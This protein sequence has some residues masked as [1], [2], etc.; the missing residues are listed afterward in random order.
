MKLGS[1]KTIPWRLTLEHTPTESKA[2]G[3]LLYIFVKIPYKL[4]NDLNVYCPK[5]LE[6]VF[7]ELLLSNKPSQIIGTIYKHPSMNA[8]TFTNGHL[9][10]M[11]NAIHYE[12][13]ITLLT[14][15]FNV[16]LINYDKKRG[17]YNFFELLFNQNF[18][19]QITL[20]TRVNEKSATL[21]DNI[22]VNNPSFKYLCGNITTSISDHLPQFIILE[23]FKEAI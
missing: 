1:Q 10:N 7:T 19:P 17:T 12:N 9:K 5:Q 20:P 8:S 4:R 21:I 14:V 16:N 3:Y 18:T 6:S 13:K 11:L 15:D 23:N 22:F 2:G